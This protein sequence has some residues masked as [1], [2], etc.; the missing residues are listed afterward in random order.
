MQYC[1][2]ICVVIVKCLPRRIYGM[3]MAA[4]KGVSAE[5]S[6]FHRHPLLGI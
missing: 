1:R 3:F 6:K 5:W 4:F 2:N